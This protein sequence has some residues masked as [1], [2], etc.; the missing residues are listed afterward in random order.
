M[1]D[2][3][4]VAKRPQTSFMMFINARYIVVKSAN[5]ELNVQGIA[6]RIVA[7]WRALDE[8]SRLVYETAA[9][10]ANDVY[11]E[12]RPNSAPI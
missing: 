6:S 3:R 4:K 1:V 5:P 7:E 11:D 8:Q 9:K 2:L 10:E 12:N